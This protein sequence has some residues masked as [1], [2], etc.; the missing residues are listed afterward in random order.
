[1]IIVVFILPMMGFN[2]LVLLTQYIV[3]PAMQ[4]LFIGIV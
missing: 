3:V 4:L 2:P 1:L